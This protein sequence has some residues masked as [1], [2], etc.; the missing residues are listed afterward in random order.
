M[1][2]MFFVA[3]FMAIS[4][5]FASLSSRNNHLEEMARA[6]AVSMT[7]YRDAVLGYAR[8]NPAFSG[9]APDASVTP[10]AATGYVKRWNWTN[11]IVA[12]STATIYTVDASLLNSPA[13]VDSLAKV[14]NGSMLVG[15]TRSGFLHTA[16]GANTG[17]ASTATNNSPTIIATP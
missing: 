7:Q 12:G 1:Y 2:M 3:F 5:G 13:L 10:Y 11:N 4:A 17:V 14:S 15:V 9:T 16:W 6:Q 8:A